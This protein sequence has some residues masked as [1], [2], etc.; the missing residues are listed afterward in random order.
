MCS[1]G[2]I[3]DSCCGPTLKHSEDTCECAAQV[4]CV[5]EAHLTQRLRS[6]EDDLS[7]K[8]THF[9]DL[10]AFDESAGSPKPYA[11]ESVA[12]LQDGVKGWNEVAAG[13]AH[14]PLEV[15]RV[16]TSV[17]IRL[18]EASLQSDRHAIMN[19]IAYG[20]MTLKTSSNPPPVKHVAYDKLNEFVHSA[21]ASAELYRLA[22]E[23][24]EG[25]VERAKELLSLGADPNSFVREGRFCEHFF[26]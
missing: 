22:C 19:F 13:Q 6:R 2:L 15:A 24:P 18:A 7:S 5:F 8:S 23:R 20:A 16:G 25:C 9:L 4:W 12:I 11:P 3:L 26:T 14:F 10:V 1:C 21:F 17:D